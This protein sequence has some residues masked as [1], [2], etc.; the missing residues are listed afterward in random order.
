MSNFELIDDYLTNRLSEQDRKS[1]EQQINSDPALKAD[2]ELQK[3]IIQGLKSARVAELKA[4]LNNVPITSPAAYLSPLRIA[5]GVIGTVVLATGIYFYFNSNDSLTPG[6]ISNPPTDSVIK[7]EQT[8][9]DLK[10]DDDTDPQI[11]ELNTIPKPA[12]EEEKTIQSKKQDS[13]VIDSNTKQES[14]PVIDLVDPTEE[15]ND[16]APGTNPVKSGANNSTIS[17]AKINV[18]IISSERK[19]NAH[20]QFINGKL[21][22]YGKFDSGLYEI[23]EVNAQ[24]SRSLFLYYKTS[25]FLLDETQHEIT[26]LKEISDP[27]LKEKLKAFRSN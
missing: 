9:P 26:P 5:A 13:D 16:N 21:V 19:Y 8:T 4:M 15:L 7:N 12:G 23:I 24:R 27:V 25:Y 17:I 11:N 10:E 6:S 18:D 20:Y 1:F 14:K 2:V 22:L 3:E